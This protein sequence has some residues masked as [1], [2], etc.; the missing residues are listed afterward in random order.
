MDHMELDRASVCVTSAAFRRLLAPAVW[1][2]PYR[3]VLARAVV[4]GQDE[5][6][7]GPR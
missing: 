4:T 6:E 2:P 1:R 5:L 7:Q 3:R